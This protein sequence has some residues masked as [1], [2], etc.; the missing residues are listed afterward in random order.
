MTAYFVPERQASR[1]LLTRLARALWP[2]DRRFFAAFDQHA[3]LCVDGM[4]A[5]LQLLS[6]VRDPDGRVREVEALEKRADVVVDQVREWLQRSLFPPFSRV[7]VH[8]LISRLDDVLDLIED[9]AQ[10][11]HLYHITHVTSDAL[12]LAE[13]GLAGVQKLQAAIAQLPAMSNSHTILALCGEVDANEAQADH[14]LRAAMS[15][16]FRDET[17][18]RQLVKLKEIYELLEGVTDR[19][20]DVANDIEVLVLKYGG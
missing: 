19:C 20:K 9:A 11:V 12:R 13:L 3:A 8:D 4:Q 18:P 14:V 5:L 1:G 15:K 17:D 7:A 10:S 6:N 16:L 2:R